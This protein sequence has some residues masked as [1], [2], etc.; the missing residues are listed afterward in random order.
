MM[1]EAVNQYYDK[2]KSFRLIKFY[3]FF[4]E[5]IQYPLF[6]WRYRLIA[7]IRKKTIIHFIHIGKTGGTAIKNALKN[8][9]KPFVNQKYIIISHPHFIGLEHVLRNEK[10]FFFVRNPVDRFVS[11][12]YSRKRKGMPHI[13]NEWRKE[14]AIA[15]EKFDTPNQLALGLASSNKTLRN[16]AQRGMKSIGH[17]KTS[18]WDWFQNTRLIDKK[19]DNIIFVGSQKNLN[20][21]FEK[22]RDILEI[23]KDYQLPKNETKRHKN[24]ESLDKRLDL[25]SV[26]NIK[27][28]Y[29]KDFYFLNYLNKKIKEKGLNAIDFSSDLY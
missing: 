16:Q 26:N 7:K 1:E 17:L 19:I 14:E 22:L 2:I 11:G 3:Y 21:D 6:L 13:Y 27:W 20:S 25:Q 9:K 28:W 4:I 8:E 5:K 29:E 23:S 15:F 18:Y 10:A 24:P 12:F